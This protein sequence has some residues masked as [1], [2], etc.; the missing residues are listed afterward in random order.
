MNE[1]VKPRLEEEKKKAVQTARDEATESAITTIRQK[2][3]E[4]F[5][6]EQAAREAEGM[7]NTRIYINCNNNYDYT[8][9]LI[10]VILLRQV[11]LFPL[12]SI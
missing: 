1:L 5:D 11:K 3:K 6:A 8:F 4:Q 12:K 2:I 9:V 10:V 7:Y